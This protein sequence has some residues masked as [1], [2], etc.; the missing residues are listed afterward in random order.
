MGNYEEVWLNLTPSLVD[1]LNVDEMAYLIKKKVIVGIKK[2]NVLLYVARIAGFQLS[3]VDTL[4]SIFEMPVISLSIPICHKLFNDGEGVYP[5]SIA[6]SNEDYVVPVL[7]SRSGS[8]N[9]FRCCSRF[10]KEVKES[11][12][13]AVKVLCDKSFLSGFIKHKIIEEDDWGY[14][15]PYR[16]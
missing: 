9:Q 7:P 11:Q 1:K 6:F 5:S 3:H 15:R 14:Y 13:L 16:S 2:G 12:G 10:Y 4:P 8:V